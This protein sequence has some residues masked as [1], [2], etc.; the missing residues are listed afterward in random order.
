M[1]RLNYDPKTDMIDCASCRKRISLMEGHP[2]S[3]DPAA[4]GVCD[5]CLDL[6]QKGLLR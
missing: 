3:P 1:E 2:L 4:P 5:E 6:A